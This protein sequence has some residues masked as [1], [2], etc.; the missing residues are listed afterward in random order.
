MQF[1]K[2]LPFI[3]FIGPAFG[4]LNAAT[5]T[6][7]TITSATNAIPS[8][9]LPN[10]ANTNTSR[11]PNGEEVSIEWFAGDGPPHQICHPYDIGYRDDDCYPKTAD[12]EHI[13]RNFIDSTSGFCMDQPSG[14]V[15]FGTLMTWNSCMIQVS[16]I[17]KSFA[18]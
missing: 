14:T 3:P 1:S 4:G 17:D 11:S 15:D 7:T 5:A 13:Y 16:L 18:W 6:T 10:Y 9:V 12:C 2:L 8:L